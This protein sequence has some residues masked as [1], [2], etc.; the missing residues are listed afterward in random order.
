MELDKKKLRKELLAK[1]AAMDE[2]TVHCFS[3]LIMDQLKNTA[4]FQSAKTVGIYLSYHNEVET[5]PLIKAMLH[6]KTICVP[7]V[8]QDQTMNF[9]LFN[10][11]ENLTK[12]RYGIFEPQQHHLVDSKQI[13]LMIIP[14]VGFNDQGCRIGY[15]GGY[16]DKYLKHFHGKKIGV[17]YSLQQTNDFTA[18]KHDIAL[19]MIITEKKI[20]T[21]KP[22]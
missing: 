18:E 16:Y 3:A 15:G 2:D 14:I 1:R 7:V 22:G 21:V 9:V 12:N 5:W 19:D 4:I 10:S 13:E 6:E 17:A 20:M 11:F 8:D